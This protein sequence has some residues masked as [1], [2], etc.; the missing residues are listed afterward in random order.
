MDYGPLGSGAIDITARNA[1]VLFFKYSQ[2]ALYLERNSYNENWKELLISELNQYRPMIYGAVG[3]FYGH[4]FMCDGYQDT[5]HFHFNWGWDGQHNGYYYIDQLDPAGLNFNLYHDAIV[6]IRPLVEPQTSV[7]EELSANVNSNAVSLQWEHAAMKD[8]FY[9][10]GYN[11]FRDGMIVNQTIITVKN[12]TD[13]NVQQG[14]HIYTVRAVYNGAESD[15][16][17]PIEVEVES[18]YIHKYDEHFFQ[19]YPN[20]A[21]DFII[22]DFDNLNTQIYYSLTDLQGQIMKDG[23]I[24]TNQQNYIEIPVKDFSNGIYLLSVK[25]A[26]G[27]YSRKIIIAD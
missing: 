4:T 7:P 3:R 10:L 24:D 27:I 22:I 5:T 21:K 13:E 26:F 20:P 17:D 16:S 11:V 8:T 25:S 1:L 2:D 6:N 14:M 9:L 23:Q 15:H 19:A 18:S 12:F